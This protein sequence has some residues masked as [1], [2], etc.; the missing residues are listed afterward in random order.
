M[1]C[2]C[3]IS[4]ESK[5]IFLW[6]I[7]NAETLIG[8]VILAAISYFLFQK[9]DELA[10]RKRQTMLGKAI[11]HV[12]SEEIKQG[13]DALKSNIEDIKTKTNRESRKVLPFDCWEG[14]S[15]I[16]DNTI[17][18]I[19]AVSEKDEYKGFHPIQIRS[20]LKNYFS[21]IVPNANEIIMTHFRENEVEKLVWYLERSEK[22]L[23]MLEAVRKILEENS[24]F[25]K[26]LH[27]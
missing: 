15:T 2:Q 6:V 13:C 1:N 14:L 17:I 4:E 27:K 25:W 21:Y 5:T 16:P 8:P 3:L 24:K 10:N 19:Y 20:H 23:A 12:I 26:L 22:V 9:R 11:I 18:T 7:S